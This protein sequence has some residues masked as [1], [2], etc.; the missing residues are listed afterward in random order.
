MKLSHEHFWLTDSWRFMRIGIHQQYGPHRCPMGAAQAFPPAEGAGRWARGAWARRTPS[1][2]R[3]VVDSTHGS[4]LVGFARPLSSLSNLP[5]PLST[6]ASQRPIP[7]HSETGG[8]RFTRPR[9][10]GSVASF[11][12]RHLQQGQKMGSAVRF[13]RRGKGCRITAIADRHGLSVA[14]HVAGSGGHESGLVEV[15]LQ[16]RFL[17]TPP[18]R[19]IGYKADD[20]APLASRLRPRYRTQ[21]NA[22]HRDNRMRKTT[23]DGRCLRR[24]RRVGASSGSSP[25]RNTSAAW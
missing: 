22:P 19:L 16:Q 2:Q 10:T 1:A 12:R 15:S 17:S 6:V 11:H 3:G 13:D 7:A 5:S 23:Q 20:S 14:V 8:R 24:A 9:Q 4:R 18:R 25:G 21:L